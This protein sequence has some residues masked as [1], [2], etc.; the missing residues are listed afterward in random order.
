MSLTLLRAALSLTAINHLGVQRDLMSFS[1]A[2]K[3]WQCI[4]L[5]LLDENETESTAINKI[6]WKLRSEGATQQ[7]AETAS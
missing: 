2:E 6:L 4:W 7:V 5:W 1:L 3:T